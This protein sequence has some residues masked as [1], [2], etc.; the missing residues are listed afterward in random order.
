MLVKEIMTS[1]VQYVTK[2]D[3]I[4][5]V[6]ELISVNRFHG[7]PVV[8]DGKVV[9]IITERDFFAK[10]T[11]DLYLPSIIKFFK[12]A[13]IN[14]KLPAERKEKMDKLL[15]AKTEDIMTEKCVTILA[16]M[17]VEDLVNFFRETGFATLPVVD[18]D[19]KIIGIV[20]VGDIIRLI[21]IQP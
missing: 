15:N 13:E 18:A 5:K 21:K 4:L 12:E 16:D 19:E 3:S 14:E 8:E 11:V 9:G 10:D 6:A 17:R 1:D 7:V 20:T 2:K